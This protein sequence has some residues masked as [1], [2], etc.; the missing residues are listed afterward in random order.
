M[1]A[2]SGST[3]HERDPYSYRRDPAVPDFPDDRP[4]IVFDG[5]CALCA[6][7]ARLVLRHDR[8]GRYRLLHAQSPLGRA[9]YVHYGLDPTDYETNILIADGRAWF[10][11]ESSIRMLEGLGFPWSLAAIFRIVPVAVRDRLYNF[12]AVNRLRV[13]GRRD[14]CYVPDAHDADRLLS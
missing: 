3:R 13:F 1:G 6:G 9:L 7:W 11:S 2:A 14:T 10:K 8:A 5:Y 12:V 4:V